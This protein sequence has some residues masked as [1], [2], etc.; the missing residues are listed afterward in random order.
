MVDFGLENTYSIPPPTSHVESTMSNIIDW[1]IGA[2]MI[3]GT[4]VDLG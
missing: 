4:N 1:K 3:L 2:Q